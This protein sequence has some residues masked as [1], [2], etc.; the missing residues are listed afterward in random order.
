MVYEV[1]GLGE[2]VNSRWTHG[3]GHVEGGHMGVVM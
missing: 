1:T 3:C 2:D